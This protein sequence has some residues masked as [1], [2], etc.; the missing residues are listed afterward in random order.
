MHNLPIKSRG[1]SSPSCWVENVSIL[2]WI[3]WH[4]NSPPVVNLFSHLFINKC[5][6]LFIFWVGHNPMQFHLFCCLNCSCFGY[7]ELFHLTPVFFDIL[8]SPMDVCLCACLALSY[9]LT[10]QDVAS[11]SCIFPVSILES[12]IS[13][14]SSGSHFW[15]TVLLIKIWELN[16]LIGTDA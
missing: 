7:W 14:R 15:R 16:V 2:F 4:G 1:S 11:S 6:W 13:P 9:F 10:L 8:P 12:A 5:L 3:L